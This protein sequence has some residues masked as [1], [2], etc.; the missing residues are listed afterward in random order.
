MTPL[1]HQKCQH[2]VRKNDVWGLLAL[3][4]MHCPT[5]KYFYI[6]RDSSGSRR[7]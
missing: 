5:L 4:T 3:H 2:G 7:R 6:A 1:K